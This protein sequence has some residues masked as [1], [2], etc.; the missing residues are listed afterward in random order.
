[1]LI[2]S[3]IKS[4]YPKSTVTHPYRT[5]Q[6]YIP[7]EFTKNSQIIHKEFPKNSQKF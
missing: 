1:L 7:K 5:P 3:L 4:N 2:K 6:P